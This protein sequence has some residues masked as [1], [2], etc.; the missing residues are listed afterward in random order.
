VKLLSRRRPAVDP[1]A[2]AHTTDRPEGTVPIG[3][4]VYRE[5]A[6]VAGRIRSMRIQPWA[7]VPTLECT[8]IDESGGVV[9]VFLGRR[10][11]AGIHLGTE[12]M[13]EGMVGQHDRRLAIINP[14]YEILLPATEPFA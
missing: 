13:V 7:G 9:V 6:R 2:L 8:I 1:N 10:R 14:D 5:R 11:I 12:L 4:V 3:E